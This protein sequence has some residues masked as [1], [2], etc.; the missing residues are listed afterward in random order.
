MEATNKKP[1]DLLPV[2]LIAGEDQL[3][4]E[5]VLKRL[6]ARIKEVGDLSLD[7]DSFQGDSASGDTIVAAC[8]TLPFLGSKRLV[9]VQRVE[10]LKKHDL[11]TLV[12][13]IAAPNPSTVLALSANKVTKNSKLYKAV[14]NIGRSAYIDCTPFSRR[15]LNQAVRGM[16]QTHGV[17][18]T[19]GAAATLVDLVGTNTIA[20]DGNIQKIAL[21][22]RGS[23]PVNENEVLSL[24]SRVTEVKP[25]EFVDAFSSRSISRTLTIFNRV[26]QTSLFALL[27]L[28]VTR[29]RELLTVKALQQR[30]RSNQL[31]SLL[32][33]PDW[34]VKN[35]ARWAHQFSTDEL[36]DILSSSR[37]TEKI[38]K[39][40]SKKQAREAFL[41][42]VVHSLERT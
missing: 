27:S 32:N 20:L 24:V 18:F 11:E 3:K 16:A 5:T 14:Q 33:L 41:R 26:E 15:N 12:S 36:I 31:A 6:H 9:E 7:Y 25:W 19:E 4:Q 1:Q 17:V 29:V 34:R 8:N 13:Y 10:K 42:W 35:H 38:M 2:Y 22:H 28:T 21:A 23:D 40:S 39:S 30:G 37:E